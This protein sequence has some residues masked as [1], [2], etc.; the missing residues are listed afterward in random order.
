M[1]FGLEKISNHI[2][3]AILIPVCSNAYILKWIQLLND[4]HQDA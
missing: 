4:S 3:F 2:R 1:V